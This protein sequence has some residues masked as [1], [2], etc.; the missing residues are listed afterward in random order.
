MMPPQ[1]SGLPNAG[2][3]GELTCDK[4][5]VWQLLGEVVKVDGRGILDQG[6]ARRQPG[7]HRRHDQGRSG[8][9]AATCSPATRCSI[10]RV[11]T[12]PTT[13]RARRASGCGP[14]RSPRRRRP[15]RRRASTPGLHRQQGRAAGRPGQPE[16][17]CCGQ[18]DY[19]MRGTESLFQNPKALES[20]LGLFKHGGIDVEGMMNFDKVPNGS[21]RGA[22]GQARAL[23]DGRD[24]GSRD[25]RQAAR[26]R[27]AAGGL[28][29]EGRRPLGRERDGSPVWWAGQGIGN[30]AFPYHSVDPTMTTP[31]RSGR[32]GSTRT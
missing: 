18:P 28:G 9:S 7:V 22:P 26:C 15:S 27:A 20:H 30:Y 3:W 14:S 12:T 4:L 5:P 11:T 29:E 32:T 13:S 17:R 8:R 23:A 16:R 10:G 24:A 25:H 2:Y 6:R 1:G 21:L 19:V 31:A